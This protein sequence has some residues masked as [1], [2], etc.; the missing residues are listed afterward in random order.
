MADHQEVASMTPE[1]PEPG[2]RQEDQRIA[3]PEPY[4]GQLSPVALPGSVK[5]QH[6]SPVFLTES[7]FLQ[8]SAREGRI[9][10]DNDL[11]IGVARLPNLHGVLGL[12]RLK[13]PDLLEIED[14]VRPC[15]EREKI[16][17]LKG[18]LR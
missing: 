4:I 9:G 18:R 7:D 2:P 1:V 14:H 3:N 12:G 5:G 17:S 11:E 13:P 6:D 16:S 10:S 8:R 15:R